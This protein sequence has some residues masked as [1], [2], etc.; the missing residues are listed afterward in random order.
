MFQDSDD[1]S[2]R[3]K[4]Q[5]LEVSSTYNRIIR[6]LFATHP[7]AVTMT[8]EPDILALTEKKEFKDP[9]QLTDFFANPENYFVCEQ[10]ANQ[11]CI[12]VRPVYFLR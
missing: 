1:E 2:Q 5:H 8:E 10:I 4:R 3:N 9:E 11:F 7:T 6:T 12:E